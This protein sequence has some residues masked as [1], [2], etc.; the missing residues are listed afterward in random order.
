MKIYIFFE[1]EKPFAGKANYIFETLFEILGF[2][3]Q[4]V[5]R[6]EIRQI[7]T[8]IILIY[9]E[10]KDISFTNQN[11]VGIIQIKPNWGDDLKQIEVQFF[12][13]SNNKEIPILVNKN[14][15]EPSFSRL[16]PDAVIIE[17]DLIFSTFFFLS[18]WEEIESGKTDK[19]TRFPLEECLCYK[20]G[21]SQQAVI[22]DYL[23]ILKE[24]IYE[25]ARA[26][27]IP[28]IRKTPWPQGK[29]MGIC[30]THDVDLIQWWFLY[31]PLRGLELI[32]NWEIGHFFKMCFSAL[33]SLLLRR[34]PILDFDKLAEQEKKFSFL[35]SFYFMIGKPNWRSLLRSDITYDFEKPFILEKVQKIKELGFE[36]GLHAS[37]G[38]FLNPALLIKEK[39]KLETGLNSPVGGLRQHFLRFKVP[40][41]WLEQKQSGF[42]YDSTFGFANQSGFRSSLAFPFYPYDFKEEQRI[43][44]L[45][46]P[47]V[48]MDRTYSKYQKGSIDKIEKEILNITKN[49]EDSQGLL[50]ILWHTHMVKELGFEGYA[51]LYEKI[52]TFFHQNNYFVSSGWGIMNWWKGRE[53]FKLK[54]EK[55]EGS[56]YS[57]E[58]ES[59]EQVQ[60]VV[61]EL[62]SEKVQK[63][64]VI[65]GKYEILPNKEVTWIKIDRIERNGK[66]KITIN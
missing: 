66:I 22:N 17:Q 10:L 5:T 39:V 50:C 32:S 56:R 14:I 41:S 45:E 30:L 6:E 12:R 3:Y 7:K 46:I 25:V 52:L 53:G 62:N 35:S 44:L 60:N 29:K 19:H 8:G 47:L 2:P 59:A 64:E 13:V 42:L 34:N 26:K 51:E 15:K 38:T 54:Q 28:L 11:K 21:F 37:Y 18:R 4:L 31:F 23:K 43:E 33:K 65:G 55:Y 57:W 63:I 16:T 48:I 27:N 1:K 58:F 40:E 24:K 36:V 20:Q 61:L 9:G 49:L